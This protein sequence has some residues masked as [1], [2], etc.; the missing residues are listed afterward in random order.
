MDTGRIICF[1]LIQL[2]VALAGL[3]ISRMTVSEMEREK[4]WSGFS[5]V[6]GDPPNPEA[7][8]ELTA[9]PFIVLIAINTVIV[10]YQLLR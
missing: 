3:G 8:A 4:T 9:W 2:V 1:A 10:G 6:G 7:F 5:V